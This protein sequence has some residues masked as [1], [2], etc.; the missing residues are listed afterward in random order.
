MT[1]FAKPRSHGII[2][3]DARPLRFGAVRLILA[4]LALPTFVVAATAQSWIA[5]PAVI[6][7][8]WL[9]DSPGGASG[10]KRSIE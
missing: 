9:C 3:P 1:E 6:V 2:H 7:F 5:L 10:D 8:L 4:V